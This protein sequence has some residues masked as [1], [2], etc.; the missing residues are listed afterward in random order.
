TGRGGEIQPAIFQHS[1]TTRR[2]GGDG[3]DRP[4]NP[5]PLPP[6]KDPS[7]QFA[8]AMTSFLFWILLMATPMIAFMTM[9]LLCIMFAL[10]AVWPGLGRMLTRAFRCVISIGYHVVGA[11]GMFIASAQSEFK[12][13]S[14]LLN[15]N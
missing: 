5:P 7:I 3:G 8:L 11:R 4:P 12:V 6:P 1:D 13:G 14:F 15:N 2:S 9:N 10:C